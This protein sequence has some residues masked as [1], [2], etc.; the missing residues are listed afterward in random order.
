MQEK[1]TTVVTERKLAPVNIRSF[2]TFGS[3]NITDCMKKYV[4][5]F[6]VVKPI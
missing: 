6:T 1:N 3:L 4:F 5:I 2:K